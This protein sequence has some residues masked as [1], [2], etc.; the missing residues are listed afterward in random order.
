MANYPPT[1][2][3]APNSYYQYK[4]ANVTDIETD[5]L[6]RNVGDRFVRATEEAGLKNFGLSLSAT[7]G[8]I[9]QDGWP[10]LYVSNDFSTP[11]Q[12]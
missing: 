11:D 4:Q 9:N 10:D 5:N 2:F 12:F 3:N 8:D 7:V 1:S 6:Y